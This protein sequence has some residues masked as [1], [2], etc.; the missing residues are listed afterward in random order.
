M[1]APAVTISARGDGRWRCGVH[2]TPRAVDY[3]P[4]RWTDDEIRRLQGDPELVVV[5]HGEGTEDPGD[6]PGIFVQAIEALRTA[7][8][9]EIRAFFKA[10][11]EDPE[12]Q[13]KIEH[14]MDETAQGVIAIGR[15]DP[16][17]PEHFTQSGVP[18]TEA[19][20]VLL[21][22][23]VSADQRDAWWE[24]FQEAQGKETDE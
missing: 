18:R 2:H 11:G 15:L 21:D 4:G 5:V 23:P 7:D 1:T 14:V 20:E 16:S 19:L 17:S 8:P 24:D 9:S 22:R 13:A 12:L 10:I 3:P 6:A